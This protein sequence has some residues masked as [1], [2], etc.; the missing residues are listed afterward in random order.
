MTLK[1]TTEPRED[2]QMAVMI[3]VP[4]ERVEQELRKAA[5]KVAS[6]YRLPGFRKGKAP[7]HIVV[8]QFG[9]A[10]LY[11]EFVDKL[12]DAVYREALEQE[13][14]EPYAV[15]S[16][17]DVSMDPLVYKVVVPLEPV[18]E[19]NDY[20]TLR[21][22]SPE[23]V[24]DDAQVDE[25]IEDFREEFAGW[26][27][28]EG[29]SAYGDMLTIDVKSVIAPAGADAEP[30]VVLDETDWDVTP[31]AENPMDPPG[32]DEALIGMRPGENKEFTL[33]WPADSRSIHAGKEGLF[34]VSLKQ[35][36]TYKKPE[37][38]DA[39]AAKV[40]V[41]I[42]T[43]EALRAHV[44]ED[45]LE[46]QAASQEELFVLKALDALVEQATLEYPPAVVE[47]QL[48]S[49]LSDYEQQLRQAGIDSLAGF[50]GQT[51]QKVEDFRESLREQAT[52]TARRN[53]VLSEIIRA[54]QLAV[55]DEEIDAHIAEMTVTQE[56]A[57]DEARTA[58]D[59]LVS[60]L[61]SPTGRSI[62]LN[63]LMRKKA[64]GRV[65]A[66]TRGE[67]L[68]E[69]PEPVAIA[70][71]DADDATDNAAAESEG[72]SN[73]AEPTGDAPSAEE[74]APEE[75]APLESAPDTSAAA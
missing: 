11:G 3:E 17:E 31:D 1:V 50:F 7:Y 2:R 47:D 72:A 65:L 30:I 60:L 75:S 12:G 57:D 27:Q 36:Q 64:I 38:D 22:E 66:I 43:I 10:N 44:R 45:L 49:M 67:E 13:K 54:E 52:L 68:P 55:S 29:P 9:L 19:L 18:V 48:D 63:D 28:T 35:I 4:Q 51:G 74:L 6:E 5:A 56:D 58:M 40:D 61:H 32:F 69:L 39:F 42:H 73:E 16:L 14:I 71:P 34:T 33:A 70:A 24:I 59:N 8:R 21:V 20:R 62:V 37:L 26:E 25:Q 41:E 15:A 53:L 46:E 23:I